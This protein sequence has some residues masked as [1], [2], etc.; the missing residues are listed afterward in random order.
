MRAVERL[1]PGPARARLAGLVEH[2]VPSAALLRARLPFTTCPPLGLVCVYRARNA[3]T[4]RS[5]LAQ[6]GAPVDVA[7]WALDSPVDGLAELTVGSGAGLRLPLLNRAAAA[8]DMSDDAWLVLADDDVVMRAGRVADV[9]QAAAALGLDVAQ[10][11]HGYGSTHSWPL[12]AHR[13]LTLARSTRFVE[14]GPLLVMSP[15]ARSHCLP[16]PEEL[17]MGWGSEVVW[18]TLPELRTGIIDAVTIVHAGRVAADYDASAL[19]ETGGEQ[20]LARLRSVGYAGI[21]ELQ[22]EHGRWRAWQR[23]PAWAC[24]AF[25]DVNP[26]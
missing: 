6:V 10:P 20:G 13:V 12:N 24:P 25:R 18:G 11:S 15:R 14:T 1:L 5:L 23:R 2:V 4:V 17:G 7:L 8:L 21:E 3:G 9:V 19:Q 22:Q 26:G 16:L